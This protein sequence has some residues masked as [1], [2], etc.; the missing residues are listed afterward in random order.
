VTIAGVRKAKSAAVR[1]KER[2]AL[3]PRLRHEMMPEAA[4][5]ESIV[6][7]FLFTLLALIPLLALAARASAARAETV[8]WPESMHLYSIP[9]P[10]GWATDQTPEHD[11]FFL[12]PPDRSCVVAVT[13]VKNDKD[14]G[15]STDSVAS[16]VA[17]DAKTESFAPVGPGTISGVKGQAYTGTVQNPTDHTTWSLKSTFVK[18]RPTIWAIVIVKWRQETTPAQRAACD[19][20]ASVITLNYH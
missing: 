10:A 3:P 7:R 14:A 12:I 2:S 8:Q 17:A 5:T 4:A 19:A 6:R 15:R 18:L 20:A 11:N 1:A 13:W 16:E 9:M